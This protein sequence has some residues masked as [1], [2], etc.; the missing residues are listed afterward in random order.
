MNA[1]RRTLAAMCMIGISVT[2]RTARAADPLFVHKYK[3]VL[4][5][6]FGEGSP[7]GVRSLSLT[8]DGTNAYVGGVS[9]RTTPSIG[10]VMIANV[11]SDTPQIAGVAGSQFPIQTRGIWSYNALAFDKESKSLIAAH[12]GGAAGSS[13]VRRINPADGAIAW[14]VTNSDRPAAMATDP[15]GDAGKPAVAYL[16]EGSPQL[17]LLSLSTGQPIQLPPQSG[18]LQAGPNEFDLN[19][20]TIG[21]DPKGNVVTASVKGCCYG[22]RS[23][24][25]SAG[26][27]WGRIDGEGSTQ[28]VSTVITKK[29]ATLC[30]MGPSV[31]ILDG[32][33]GRDLLALSVQHKLVT[34][35]VSVDAVEQKV[36]DSKVHIR[37]V[38]GSTDGVATL[39]LSGDEDG[40]G[41]PWTGNTK[42]LWF[43]PLDQGGRA[44]IVVDHKEARVDV[45]TVRAAG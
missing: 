39:E 13:F 31:A 18:S 35:T 34:H 15:K 10:I 2:A 23:A 4:G 29:G 26:P 14:S 21:F 30:M 3:I 6:H 44:L 25:V 8:C 20:R 42:A 7:D 33:G 28:G 19:W 16:V 40:V 41:T 45:Y 17:R 32:V 36:A 5:E 38:D 12:D 27:R 11:A 22:K 9:S 43:G 37:N 1:W 24:D